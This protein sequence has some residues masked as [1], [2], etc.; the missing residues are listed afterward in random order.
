[1]NLV[2]DCLDNRLLDPRGNVIGR[3]DG[4]VMEFEE[5]A[6]PTIVA[7][8]VGSVAQLRRVSARFGRWAEWLSRRYGRMRPNPWRLPFTAI[9]RDRHDYRVKLSAADASALAWEHWLREHVI[10]RIPGG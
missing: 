8:E 5:G 2:R 7:V 6:Q 4:I 1:M 3:I 10:R 9:Q